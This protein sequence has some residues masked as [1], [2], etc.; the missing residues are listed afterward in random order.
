[1]QVA[2]ASFV[3]YY[4]NNIV[5]IGPN[6]GRVWQPFTIQCGVRYFLDGANSGVETYVIPASDLTAFQTGQTFH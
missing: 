2:G 3:D 1:M 5:S 4:L 6:G